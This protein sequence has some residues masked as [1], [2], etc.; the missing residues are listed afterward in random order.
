MQRT[1][2]EKFNKH[3][4]L[5]STIEASVF[6]K[7]APYTIGENYVFGVSVHPP[8]RQLCFSVHSTRRVARD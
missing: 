4:S 8:L 1:D 3:A 7:Y 2:A 5:Y 6:I